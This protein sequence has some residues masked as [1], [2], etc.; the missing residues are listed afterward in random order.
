[1]CSPKH[2]KENTTHRERLVGKANSKQI[3]AGKKESK[4]EYCWGNKTWEFTTYTG[5][6][7]VQF[8]C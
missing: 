4:V 3:K 2:I 6:K 5:E 8:A 1:M 7:G